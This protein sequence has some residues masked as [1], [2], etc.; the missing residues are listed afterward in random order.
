MKPDDQFTLGK[1]SRRSVLS[2]GIGA[3]AATVPAL[4][5]F[6]AKAADAITLTLPWIPE[7]E[8]AFMYAAQKQGFWAK[9][10]LDVTITRGFGSGEASKN[11][12]LGRY[13][14]GQADLG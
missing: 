2:G 11:V 7:G 4:L 9:R 1:V 13:D 14:F 8:V 3:L 5:T 10:G 12:G 6:D